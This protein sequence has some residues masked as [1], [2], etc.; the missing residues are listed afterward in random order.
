MHKR[1]RIVFF[2]DFVGEADN[3]V[4]ILQV[5]LNVAQQRNCAGQIGSA[6][7]IH[8]SAAR[9]VHVLNGIREGLCI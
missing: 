5:E 9:I 2:I 6:G 1:Q 8:R 3:G 7:H 4:F